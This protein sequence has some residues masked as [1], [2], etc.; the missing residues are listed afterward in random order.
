[1]RIGT[2]ATVCALSLSTTNTV[3]Q[4]QDESFA[5]YHD[6][7]THRHNPDHA[8][9]NDRAR[10]YTDRD[11]KVILPLPGE[12]DAFTFVVY[13]DRTGGPDTGI[14]VLKDAVRDTNLLEPD[15]VM[16]VGDMIQGYNQ[17]DGWMEQMT[18]YR[19]VMNELICPWFPVA[20]NHDTY[21]RGAG[22]PEGEHDRHYEM[23]FGPLW[24]AFEHKNCMFIVLY[25]DEG[26][27]ATGEKNFSKPECQEMSEEQLSWL[28][29]M[30]TKSADA[31]HVFLFLHHPRWTGGNYGDS[32]E[33]VHE[34]LVEAGNISGVFAGHIHR[35][36]YDPRDG[37]DY[38]TLATVGGH[39]NKSVPSAGW[40]HHYNIVTV[41]PRQVAHAALPVGEVMDVREITDE[42][43]IQ[44]LTLSRNGASIEGGLSLDASS[45]GEGKAIITV[46]NPSS[47]TVEF[48]VTPESYDSTWVAW[49][50]HAHMSLE[51][52]EEVVLEFDVRR[53]GT[54]NETF[55]DLQFNVDIDMLMPGAR[56]EIPTITLNTPIKLD[57]AEIQLESSPRT[58]H[59]DGESYAYITSESFELPN[60]P[61]TL[62]CWFNAESF[63]RRTGLLAKTE[64]SEFGFFVNNAVPSFSIHLDGKYAEANPERALLSVGTWHH[65][66]GVYDGTEVRLYLDGRLVDTVLASGERTFNELP[67]MIGADVSGNGKATSHFKGQID[68]VR[69][70][71][72]ALYTGNSFEPAR[73]WIDAEETVLLLKMDRGIGPW[74]ID[75]SVSAAH[76]RT[77][78]KASLN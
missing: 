72:S 9:S 1:M 49:P 54:L 11:S 26:N 43:A 38:I 35:M 6:R 13:G 52:G 61:M 62:E 22:K 19:G 7:H 69:L 47:R 64:G 67:L 40:L 58:L 44:S 66:A 78:G 41:R 2:I 34:M 10:F 55:R 68:E 70:S 12:E 30:L 18:E 59:L 5:P 32:W 25:T 17:T 51:A 3:S 33:Q 21:W 73:D 36:R 28:S 8:L 4:V 14:N 45:G 76:A 39:Q 24:Y 20:G 16:T 56:Y 60:G 77:A 75:E 71:S 57:L 50:D 23:H 74:V 27:E 42:M 15:F 31:Q 65:L 48:A 63:G 53:T 37:I 46:S 29:Q